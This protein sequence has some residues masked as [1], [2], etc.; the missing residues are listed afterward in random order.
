LNLHIAETFLLFSLKLNSI[1]SILGDY[2]LHFPLSISPVHTIS[3]IDI[4][5]CAP[6][7][8]SPLLLK[9]KLGICVIYYLLIRRANMP[10][11]Y[12]LAD[13]DDSPEVVLMDTATIEQAYGTDTSL[14]FM[15]ESYSLDGRYLG[16]SAL[17]D[18]GVILCGTEEK[19]VEAAFKFG[20][21][22]RKKVCESMQ[23]R[24]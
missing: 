4:S 12:Y 14:V 9:S 15:V 3:I 2:E 20:T 8:P 13:L 24:M 10:W 19:A 5:F 1:I 7:A 6:V 22:F 23:N 16:R 17:K 11:L 18:S 21:E